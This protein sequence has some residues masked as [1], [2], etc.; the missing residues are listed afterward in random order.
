M[1]KKNEDQDKKNNI[2]NL[3]WIVKLK[4]IK[5]YKKTTMT[6]RSTS[7]YMYHIMRKRK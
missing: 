6:N 2:K 5:N 4:T 7:T 3:D 1:I